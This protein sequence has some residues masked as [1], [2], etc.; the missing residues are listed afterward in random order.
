MFDWWVNDRHRGIYLYPLARACGGV[1]NRQDE[2]TEGAVPVLMNLPIYLEF[3][4]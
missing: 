1:G 4:A 2:N 3:I